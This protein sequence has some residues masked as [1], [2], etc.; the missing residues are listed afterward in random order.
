MSFYL[1]AAVAALGGLLF[2]YDTGVISSALLFVRQVMSLSATMQ[3]IVVA[4]AIAGAAIGAAM[5]GY[6]SDRAGRRRVILGAGLLFVAGAVISAAAPGVTVLLIGRFLV[7]LAIGVASLLTPLYLAEIAP[8]RHRGAIVSL[9]QLCIT[10]GI[11]VSY[12]VGFAFAGVS[13]GWRW[14]LALGVLPGII[15]SAGMLFLPESPRWLAGHDQ[16]RDAGIV[17]RQ[18]RGNVDVGDE[19]SLLRTDLAREGRRLARASEL[20]APRLRRPLTIGI[21][22]AM[23]QQITGIN[24]VIYF[25]P[26]IFQSVGLSSAATSILATVAVGVVNVVMTIVSIRLIDRLG[27]RRLL[28]WSLGG[29]AVTLLMLCGA[30]HAGASG[31]LAWIAVLSVAAYVGFFAIGLG[32]VF[33]LL[34]AEIFPLALR[35]RAMSLATVANWGF[36]LIVSATFLDLVSALG[37]A[38][39]FLVYAI[40]SI[41]AVVFIASMVPETKGRSLEQIE[42]A[43]ETR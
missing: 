28:L 26:T 21:G 30:F 39:V 19:L 15:L 24:T 43:L 37:G 34:I 13:G 16:L 35:G 38:G 9:N 23:F 27:R 18:L 5:A 6:L 3:G 20:L 25:A 33:W 17:L 41:M 29:M 11:L 7:G 14:M 2:G 8:A 40:L 32:P 10:G 22:L 42:D 36:N 1:I 4:I 31:Q 12:L